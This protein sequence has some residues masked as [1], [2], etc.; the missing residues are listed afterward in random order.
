MHTVSLLRSEAVKCP[1]DNRSLHL[2]PCEI[3]YDGPADVNAY[4]H[5]VPVNEEAGFQEIVPEGT[6]IS[7]FRGHRLLGVQAD[8]PEG[9]RGYV[10]RSEDLPNH[11]DTYV[12][13]DEGEESSHAEVVRWRPTTQFTKFNIW[14]D[15][16]VPSTES[17]T[18]VR[19]LHWLQLA[20]LIHAPVPA[21]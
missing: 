8:L 20:P 4:F 13:E 18:V 6:L 19:S 5:P 15:D 1:A 11:Q 17:D 7:H 14:L 3:K 10:F 9:H 12:D 16:G 2:L 21:Q